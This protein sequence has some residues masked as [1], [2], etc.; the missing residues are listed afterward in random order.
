MS[1]SIRLRR[2]RR[3]RRTARVTSCFW[4]RR[5]GPAQTDGALRGVRHL[6]ANDSR[7]RQCVAC[8]AIRKVFEK[9]LAESAY[10][11]LSCGIFRV[12]STHFTRLFHQALSSAPFTHPFSEVVKQLWTLL[13]DRLR[14]L[15]N[16]LAAV[17]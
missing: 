6:T 7:M 16:A 13:R 17:P 5:A 4:P 9:S 3:G 1:L 15:R 11:I 12:L 2:D 10:R 8:E 14:A